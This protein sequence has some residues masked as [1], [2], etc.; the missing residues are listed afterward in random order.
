MFGH[1]SES[2]KLDTQRELDKREFCRDAIRCFGITC[3]MKLVVESCHK[4]SYQDL[5]KRWCDLANN[6]TDDECDT[7]WR[8]PKE[9]RLPARLF[10]EELD[11]RFHVDKILQDALHNARVDC[12]KAADASLVSILRNIFKGAEDE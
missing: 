4:E 2:H 8:D 1:L 11:N 7:L 5:K 6:L 10:D 3:C 9:A 12:S